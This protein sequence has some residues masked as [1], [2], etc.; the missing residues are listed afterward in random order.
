MQFCIF[1]MNNSC[2]NPTGDYPW[3]NVVEGDRIYAMSGNMGI[4]Y[5]TSSLTATVTVGDNSSVSFDFKAWGEVSSDDVCRFLIDNNIIFHYGARNNDWENYSAQLSAGTH[6]L[7]WRF[8]KDASRNGAGDYFAVDNVVVTGL[9]T[10]AQGDVDG[11]GN[12]NIADV[13]ALIDYLLSGNATGISLSAADVNGDSSVNIADVTDLI[14]I[15]L[16]AN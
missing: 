11:D 9:I 7:E 10:V 13:T 14:D 1:T 15:L 6:T 16:N 4:P 5:S 2:D 12:V 8:T 3:T